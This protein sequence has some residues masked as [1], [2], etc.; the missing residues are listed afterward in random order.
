MKKAT[1]I[2]LALTLLICLTACAKE[3]SGSASGGRR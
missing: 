1:A 2:I 3:T